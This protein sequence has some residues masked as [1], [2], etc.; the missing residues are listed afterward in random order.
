MTPGNP[1]H[2]RP[3]FAAALVFLAA[4]ATSDVLLA[5]VLA[6]PGTIGHLLEAFGIAP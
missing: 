1:L 4:A 3:L 5:F 2:W 6:R